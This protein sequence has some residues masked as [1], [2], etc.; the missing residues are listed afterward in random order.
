MRYRQALTRVAGMFVVIVLSGCVHQ[1]TPGN[2]A[3]TRGTATS[4]APDTI[5]S[6]ATTPGATTRGVTGPGAAA[7]GARIRDILQDMNAK[8]FNPQAP[9]AKGEGH[10][11]GLFINWRGAWQGNQATAAANTN[12]GG[13]GLSD[14]QSGG[15]SRHDPLTDLVYLVNLYSYEAIYPDDRE[16]AADAAR[17]EPIVKDEYSNEGYY[18]CWVYF[19]LRDLAALR[20]SQGWDDIAGHFAA[21]VYRHYYDS[22][23][24]VIGDPRHNGAYRP[25]FAAECGAML[26][27]IGNRQRNA[28]WTQAGISTLGDLL[29]RA[30]NPTTHLFPE[31]LQPGPARDTVTHPKLTVGGEAQLFDAFLT[32][33]D[34]TGN[35]SYLDAVIAGV[36]SLYS[37]AIG[38]WD[39]VDGGFFSSVNADGTSLDDH[40]KQ[41]R[42]AWMLVLLAHL[43]RIQAGGQWARKEKE[44]LT[45]VRDRLWQPSINGYP[46]RE[47]PGFLIYHSSEGPGH[48]AVVENWVTSEAMGIACQSLES[49]LLR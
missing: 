35:K 24:G 27:D 14:Q 42:Q 38:L 15:T 36:D 2:S 47:T 7:T 37:P 4:T 39:S 48:S 1:S 20:P 16:F 10:P 40:Y 22:Q 3:T 5:T 18:R 8:A 41:T 21:G 12:I 32:A 45:V 29:S 11:G 9:P 46:Y 44:M 28:A 49:Q 33:Y 43:S 17:M 23:A 19:Q 13:S 30:Q 25:D 34:L 26:I 6:G 31:Q